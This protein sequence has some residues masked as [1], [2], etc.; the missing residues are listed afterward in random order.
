MDTS[1][2]FRDLM[3]TICTP[4]AVAT[5]MSGARPHGTTISAFASLSLHPPLVTM[6]LDGHSHLLRM[7]R[8]TK[9]FGINVLAWHQEALATAFAQ[10]GHIRFDTVAWSTD[11]G[12][13]RI[14]GCSSWMTCEVQR[15]IPGGD[16]VI[17]IGG[18][19]H[20]TY[21]S[22]PPLIYHNRTFGTHSRFTEPATLP[23]THV[24][25]PATQHTHYT[26]PRYE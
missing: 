12:L 5:S 13:P 19:T 20:A 26:A 16:H 21:T 23:R 9:R 10:P 18:V 7:L 22:A 17:A 2:A 8:S 3:A 25:Q 4:V 1:N 24:H 15:L 6:A 14:D 11:H